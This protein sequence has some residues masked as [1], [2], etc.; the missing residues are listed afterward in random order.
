NGSGGGGGGGGSNGATEA[1]RLNGLLRMP[2]L[3][4]LDYTPSLAFAPRFEASRF[5]ADL[6]LLSSNRED[7]RARKIPSLDRLDRNPAGLKG[8]RKPLLEGQIGA[9]IDGGLALLVAASL[10]HLQ[11]EREAGWAANADAVEG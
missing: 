3:S 8:R 2:T 6:L 11:D 4:T 7:Y 9:S 1:P 10:K 5:L